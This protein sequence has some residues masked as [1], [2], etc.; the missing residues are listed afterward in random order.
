MADHGEAVQ[1]N[2][3]LFLFSFLPLALAGFLVCERFF[4]R[5]ILPW[6]VGS[7]LVFYGW[8]NPKALAILLPSALFNYAVGTAINRTQNKGLL[9][10]GVAANLILLGYFKYAGFL[11]GN[12]NTLLHSQIAIG[13][14]ILP[15]GISFFTFAQIAWLVSSSRRETVPCTLIE[16]LAFASFFP[17]IVS[18]PIPYQ[19]ELVPQF[20]QTRDADGRASDF[21]V[22]TT[23]FAMGL[24]KKVMVADML[25]PWATQVFWAAGQGQPVTMLA[26]WIGALAYTFQLYYDFSGYSD[27]AIGVAR[28]FGYRLPLNFNSP[29]QSTSIS[30]FWRRWHMSLSRF[31]RD[32][33]YFSLGGSRCAAWRCYMNLFI[34]MLLGG[35]WHGAGWTFIVWGGLHGLYLVIN[36]AWS[37]WRDGAEKKSPSTAEIW[38]ARLITFGAVILAW[39]FFRAANFSE[40]ASILKGM[41]GWNGLMKECDTLFFKTEPA[42]AHIIAIAGFPVDSQ[43]VMLGTLLFLLWVAW[44]CPN[45]QQLLAAYS[46]GL[47]TYGKNIEPHPWAA[48]GFCWKPSWGWLVL[49]ALVL[50]W[51]F[52]QMTGVTSF[53]Y[54]DF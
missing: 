16:Y 12:L 2:S 27:M 43:W 22:G 13:Q 31:L 28:L 18:G 54:A 40:G 51:G 41:V 45:S 46:P 10:F 19:K 9:A 21:A 5:G 35:L 47:V 36:H 3:A 33:L 29:Y 8:S 52:V 7:S 39:I 6:L 50:A 48:K 38:G 30:D 26:A 42:I 32:F 23:L 4:K 34:T 15:L 11:V 25:A 1:F 53:L 24:F 20:S 44:F 14:I 49:T 17:Q 37:S